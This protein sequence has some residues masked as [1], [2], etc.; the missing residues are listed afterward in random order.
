[1]QAPSR[2]PHLAVMCA[3]AAA[4]RF[5]ELELELDARW[6]NSFWAPDSTFGARDARVADAGI[7]RMRCAGFRESEAARVA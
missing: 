5:E 6:R 2:R 1:M 7:V 4:E 3:Q